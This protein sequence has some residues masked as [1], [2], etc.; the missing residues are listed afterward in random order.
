MTAKL[1]EPAANVPVERFPLAAKALRTSTAR[2]VRSEPGRA[3]T[4][5]RT[6]TR[7]NWP[8]YLFLFLLRIFGQA[9]S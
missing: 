6:R 8:L 9:R 4:P 2:P 3:D 7:N 1:P 5:A